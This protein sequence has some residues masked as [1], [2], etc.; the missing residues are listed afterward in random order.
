MRNRRTTVECL[1]C[2]F[3]DFTGPGIN[4]SEEDVIHEKRS[5]RAMFP[6]QGGI[7]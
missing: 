5:L 3:Y 1:T 6:N 4:L 7:S 2:I